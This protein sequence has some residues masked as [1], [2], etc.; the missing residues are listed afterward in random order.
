MAA[1]ID[2]E[3]PKTIVLNIRLNEAGM[4]RVRDVA[5]ARGTSQGTSARWLLERGLDW[6]EGL[7]AE[8]KAIA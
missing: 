3:A 2:E 6:F 1:A 7:S 4:Q 8:Q 5:R